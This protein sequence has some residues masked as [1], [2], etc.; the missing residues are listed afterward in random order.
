MSD[1]QGQMPEPTPVVEE[2][3]EVMPAS[4]NTP[5]PATDTPELP[6]EVSERTKAEFEKLKT[7]NKE[8][9]DK[10][11]QYEGKG[12]SKGSVLDEFRIQSQV[13]PA[14]AEPSKLIDDAGYVDPDVLNRAISSAEERARRAEEL[15]SRATNEVQRFQETQVVREVHSEFPQLDPNNTTKFDP[16]FYDLVRNELI[17][18]MVKGETQDLRK[19]A[20]KITSLL[21]PTARPEK[22]KTAQ[23]QKEVA[24]ESI[25][26]NTGASYDPGD[27]A[28]RTRQGDPDALAERLAKSGY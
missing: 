17:G 15:A 21:T 14:Q 26:S 11:A 5:E 4:E 1:T 12:N 23:V 25:S 16:Q 7:H 2:T 6:A 19:A 28:E 9:A 20:Q 22:N 13:A 8:L 24:S 10:V 3:T 27:L 18:Q